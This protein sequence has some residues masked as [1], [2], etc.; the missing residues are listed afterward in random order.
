MSSFLKANLEKTWFVFDME[1]EVVEKI[2]NIISTAT[3]CTE[4]EEKCKV[5][6]TNGEVPPMMIDFWY[7]GCRTSEEDMNFN[8]MAYV[9][10][11]L[12]KTMSG[13]QAKMQ[14]FGENWVDIKWTQHPNLS[15]TIKDWLFHAKERE[16]LDSTINDFLPRLDDQVDFCFQA[17]T[18]QMAF[19]S[20]TYEK[21]GKFALLPSVQMPC[22]NRDIDL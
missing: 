13:K 20:D 2:S 22:N 9:Q 21:D 4:F 6:I 8:F 19:C 7:H 18:T 12:E 16:N 11:K 1:K 10:Q 3:D 5:H 14:R 15:M 17:L